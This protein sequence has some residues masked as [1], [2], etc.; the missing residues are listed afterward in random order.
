MNAPLLLAIVAFLL[1]TSLSA[2][3]SE[4]KLLRK[5]NKQNEV[6][7]QKWQIEVE[8]TLATAGRVENVRPSRG[9]DNASSNSGSNGK[10]ITRPWRGS[11]N[12]YPSTLRCASGNGSTLDREEIA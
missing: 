5:F 10:G 12:P 11:L 8:R 1:F 7:V 3:G 2:A 6:S 9:K 4:D